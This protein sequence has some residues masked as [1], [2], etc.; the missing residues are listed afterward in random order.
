MVERCPHEAEVGGSIPPTLTNPTINSKDWKAFFSRL[1]LSP[2]AYFI[3]SGY[4]SEDSLKS[5]MKILKFIMRRYMKDHR[6][7]YLVLDAG[8]GIGNFV[9]LFGI[10]SYVGV[11]FSLEAVKELKKKYASSNVVVADVQKL[12]FR[13]VF[14]FVNAVEVLQYMDDHSQFLG[15]ISRVSLPGA[16][17]VIVAPNPSSLFWI[18][19]QRIKGKSPL[20]FLSIKE[21]FSIARDLSLEPLDLFGIFTLPSHINLFVNIFLTLIK[22]LRFHIVMWFSKSY[23]IVLRKL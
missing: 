16:L 3:R 17:I 1:Y 12:P 6:S 2:Q 4:G 14:S 23:V 20:K 13:R 7:N 18:L 22:T 21:L 15:E 8:C 9:H 10:Y 11:D 5:R 19:R